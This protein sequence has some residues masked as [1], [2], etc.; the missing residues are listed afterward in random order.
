MD[1]YSAIALITAALLVV[2]VVD[3]CHN[4]LADHST[5]VKCIV[6]CIS[7]GLALLCEWAC[8]RLNGAPSALIGL[9]RA[10]K[11]AEFCLAPVTGVL[12]AHAYSR[13]KRSIAIVSAIVALHAAFQIAACHSG[14]VLYIDEANVYHRGKLYWIYIVVFSLSVAYCLG[15]VVLD[16]VRYQMRP[17]AALM[18]TVLFLAIGLAIQALDSDL[19]VDYLCIAIANLQLYNHR[20]R[21]YSRMDGLTMLLNRVRYEKDLERTKPPAVV[22]NMDVNGF[23]LVND[24][25]G[26]TAG[27]R[28]LRQI[29]EAVRRVYGRYGYCYRPGGDEFCVILTE[30]L[31][32]VERLNE[33]FAAAIDKL[34]QQDPQTPDV[35]VGYAYYDGEGTLHDA[36]EAADAMMYRN[37]S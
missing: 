12:A 32:N 5:T 30:S 6:V 9:H 4:R 20:C 35:S 1:L 11:T 22:I 36:I 16:E 13:I 15:C 10:V 28:Y 25:C 33:N 19:R 3:V 34:R 8:V 21:L 27:D 23:K 14:L 2:T 37:K 24:T 31:S 26:H 18:A 7:I 29:A 17:D